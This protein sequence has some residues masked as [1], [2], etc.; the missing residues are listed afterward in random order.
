MLLAGLLPLHPEQSERWS[1]AGAWQVPVGDRYALGVRS[2]EV[3]A[4]NENRGLE[5]SQGRATH[6]GADLANGRAGD[7][8][9]AAASGLV[10]RT[11]ANAG[12]GYGGYVVL[13]HRVP[14]GDLVYSVYAHL[15]RGTIRVEAGERVAAG[16]PLARVGQTGRASTPHLHFEVRRAPDPTVRWEKAQVV[17]PMAYVLARL[18]EHRADTTWMRP[19]LEWGEYQALLPERVEPADALT[20]E[21]WWRML[22]QAARGPLIDYRIDA[23]SLRDSLVE[24]GVLPTEE[25]WQ[26]ASA[27]LDWRSI[28]RDLKR[29]DELGVRLG[30]PTVPAEAHRAHCEEMWDLPRPLDHLSQLARREDRPTT[31]EACVLL[32]SACGPYEPAKLKSAPRGKAAKPAKRPAKKK[33]RTAP[34]A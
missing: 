15:L 17:E 2:G 16:E 11:E 27:R 8:V 5:W 23:A 4:F 7:T 31:V 3:P 19:Y 10:V 13:A 24:R 12:N 20:R 6:Q 28:A 30:P 21:V 25:G 26:A 32:A 18:P 29:L 9:R 14:D 34:R 22:A 33:R 1:V